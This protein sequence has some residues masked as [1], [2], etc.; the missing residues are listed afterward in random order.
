MVNGDCSGSD[1]QLDLANGSAVAVGFDRDCDVAAAG[2]VRVCGQ[3]FAAFIGG[4]AAVSGAD[5]PVCV[6]RFR[7]QRAT[8]STTI[9]WDRVG[10][11]RR[12]V[13]FTRGP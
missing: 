10:L 6:E 9:D 8:R 4:S 5:D 7:V 12:G 3:T 11:G 2:S 13:L 1:D